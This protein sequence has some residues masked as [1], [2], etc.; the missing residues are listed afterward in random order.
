[1]LLGFGHALLLHL[2]VVLWLASWPRS[3][4]LL[5]ALTLASLLLGSRAAG[6]VWRAPQH[7]R[8]YI[9]AAVAI[10]LIPYGIIELIK[11]LRQE[12]QAGAASPITRDPISLGVI[13]RPRFDKIKLVPPQPKRI[14]LEERRQSASRRQLIPFRGF[15]WIFQPPFFKPPQSSA[16]ETG[17]PKDFNF[18]SN[19]G[20]LIRLSADERFPQPYS[21]RGA[22]ALEFE[23]EN[24]EEGLPT[25]R[26]RL[27]LR[28]NSDSPGGYLGVREQPVLF[29]NGVYTLR[30]E[31]PADRPIESFD[32]LTLNFALNSQRLHIVPRISLSGFR[33]LY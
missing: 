6:A 31:L 26:A 15:Y 32:Q 8:R 7:W 13:L 33:F 21:L 24:A 12:V 28:N 2:A 11:I 1:M 16:Q 18:R 27:T 10:W 4:L 3:A 23:L 14:Q 30:F 9:L 19:D 20:S 17:T 29:R 25:F 5:A 22:H